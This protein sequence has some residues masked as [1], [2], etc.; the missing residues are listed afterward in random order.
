LEAQKLSLI[1]P[2]YYDESNIGPLVRRCIVV[3]RALSPEFEIII[4]EDGSP[5]ATGR[6]ADELAAEFPEV[7]AL[8]HPRNL[9]HGAVLKTGVKNAKFP[10][11]AFMDGD[12]QYDPGDFPAMLALL[13]GCH[14]VQ[15]RRIDYPNGR[16]RALLSLLYNIAVRSLFR[17][18]FRDLGCSIKMFRREILEKATPNSDGIFAQGE[19]VLRAHLAGFEVREAKVKCYPRRTGRSHSMTYNNVLKMIAEVRGFKSALEAE[20]N[21]AKA[22]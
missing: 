22:D 19:L 9:G 11:I 14:V 2:A 21:A 13:D 16:L 20:R 18:P 4:V 10:V 3:L 6:A 5:D 12:G 15:G 8:H 17:A 7:T 1:C